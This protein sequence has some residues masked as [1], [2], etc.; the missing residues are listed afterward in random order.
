MHEN[1]IFPRETFSIRPET[2][3]DYDRIDALVGAAFATAHYSDGT[4]VAWLHAVRRSPYYLPELSF[5]MLE[6]DCLV[7]HILCSQCEYPTA[8][9]TRYGVV[10]APLAIAPDAQGRRLGGKLLYH[11][12]DAAAKLGYEVAF[13]EGYYAYY[14]RVGFLRAETFGLTAYDPTPGGNELLIRSTTEQPLTGIRPGIIN[15]YNE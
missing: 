11:T 7:G 12:L 13:L 14:S 1:N 8:D 10:I 2:P 9:G 4:E 5:L 6:G 15:I 3:E